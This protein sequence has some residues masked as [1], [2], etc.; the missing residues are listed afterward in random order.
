[1]ARRR[2]LGSDFLVR[3]RK[4]A[5]GESLE[6]RPLTAA[7]RV[8]GVLTNTLVRIGWRNSQAAVTQPVR[9]YDFALMSMAVAG[10]WYALGVPP[11]QGMLSALDYPSTPSPQSRNKTR[12]CPKTRFLGTLKPMSW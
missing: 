2:E 1:M 4:S 5:R 6:P 7:D 10:S 3:L 9:L 12:L 8:A 11:T